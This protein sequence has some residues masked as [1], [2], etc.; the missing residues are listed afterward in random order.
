MERHRQSKIRHEMVTEFMILSLNETFGDSKRRGR[1]R[2][3]P[4]GMHSRG[5]HIQECNTGSG[6]Q[7]DACSHTTRG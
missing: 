5:I 1:F 4:W 2:E 6:Q 7:R 3:T